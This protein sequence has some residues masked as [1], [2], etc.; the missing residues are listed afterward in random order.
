MLI[1]SKAESKLIENVFAYRVPRE[2]VERNGKRIC[3][4]CGESLSFAWAHVQFCMKW[5]FTHEIKFCN[6]CGQAIYFADD[7][8]RCR[9]QETHEK[10]G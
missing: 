1:C 7:L 6:H 9:S 8:S 3:P 4:N 10:K 2:V 5:N